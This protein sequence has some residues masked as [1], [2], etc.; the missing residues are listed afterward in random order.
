MVL[1]VSLAL[2][3]LG[4]VHP[5]GVDSVARLLHS[6]GAGADASPAKF[7]TPRQSPVTVW[8]KMVAAPKVSHDL[9]DMT[10]REVFAST[11]SRPLLRVPRCLKTP[12]GDARNGKAPHRTGIML[13]LG[14]AA[15]CPPF[16]ILAMPMDQN[17]EHS[18]RSRNRDS[19]AR[20]LSAPSCRAPVG[21]IPPH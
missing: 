16:K 1:L 11:V 18:L 17:G 19:M 13:W 5:T 8:A 7:A 9:A 2:G 10:G 6:N 12:M 3:A 20:P 21:R 4:T 15:S 14:Q